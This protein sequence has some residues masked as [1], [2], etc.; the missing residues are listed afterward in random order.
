ML[1]RT[2]ALTCALLPLLSAAQDSTSAEGGIYPSK[3]AILSVPWEHP[4]VMPKGVTVPSTVD[5]S[6]WFPPAGDQYKQASCSGWAIGYGLATYM[7]NKLRGRPS[8]T[9]FL[10]DPANVFSPSFVYNLT[11]TGEKNSNCEVGVQLPNAIQLVCDTGCATWLQFPVDTNSVHCITHV[12]DSAFTGAFRHRMARP[13][14]LDNFNSAQWKYH[15]TQGRPVVFFVSISDPL[16]LTGYLT[17]GKPFVWNES[18][19]SNWS[20]REGHIMVC[21]GYRD[22]TFIALNSWGSNWGQRGYV[23]I[24]DSVLNWACSDAYVLQAGYAPMLL[25]APKTADPQ[26]LG[27]DQ[28]L[29]GTL[30]DGETHSADSISYRVLQTSADGLGK[31]IEILDAGTNN[32]A[33]SLEVRLGQPVTFHHEGDLYT[34]TWLGFGLFGQLRYRLVENDPVQ[35]AELKHQM[36][37]IDRNAD[38]AIDG[39]W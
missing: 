8:D 32:R 12:P 14:S 26:K 20:G 37:M 6:S 19:P 24:P 34:F 3:E 5:L 28:R 15:L 27:H 29:T 25:V 30:G 9:T 39:R 33:H 18:F 11:A 2:F 4:F 36:E 10:A 22:N 35:H 17:D 13:V 16:F 1:L 21:T 31:I 38:G 7:W 23:E